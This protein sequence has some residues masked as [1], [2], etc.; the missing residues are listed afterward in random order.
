[1][2]NFG[3]PPILVAGTTSTVDTA[4]QFQV[5]QRARDNSGNE[6]VYVSGVTSCVA[7]SWVTINGGTH[8]I[9]L[10]VS[11]DSGALGVA[12]A[13]INAATSY[14]WVQ[15]FGTNTIALAS[16]DGTIV[17][18]GGQLQLN[19]S[20]KVAAQGTS[21]G[22]AAGDYIFG[23]YAYSG[24]PTSSVDTFTVYLNFPHTAQAAAVASS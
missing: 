15:V 24:Q 6:Y 4:P 7:G 11:G 16:S 3:T 10:S 1:M 23:A 12:M 14:G 5:G 19:A 17:S 13:A 8:A 18:G 22:S 2:A 20:G 21:T 9:T